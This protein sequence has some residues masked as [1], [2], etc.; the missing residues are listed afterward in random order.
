MTPYLARLLEISLNNATNPRNWKTDTVVHIYRGSYRS[1]LSNNRPI[2][3]NS[4]VC[5]QLQHVLVGYFREW[6]DK[7]DWT[8][9]GGI[10]VII[11]DYSK[12]FHL[13]PYDRLL[14]KL[15]TLGVDSRVVVWIREFL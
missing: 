8:R 2:S 12:A 10:D 15:V 5:K 9:G 11:T 3:L 6:W 7:N 14:T 4:V 13:V 1:A